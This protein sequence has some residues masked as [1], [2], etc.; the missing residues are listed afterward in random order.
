VEIIITYSVDYTQPIHKVA[1]IM[2]TKHRDL[3]L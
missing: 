1:H 2:C 3:K